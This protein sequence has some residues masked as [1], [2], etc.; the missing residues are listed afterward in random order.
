MLEF[1]IRSDSEL[2]EIYTV[3]Y[4]NI[5]ECIDSAIYVRRMTKNCTK[6]WM[7]WPF[8]VGCLNVDFLLHLFLIRFRVRISDVGPD[9]SE[10]PVN[11]REITRYRSALIFRFER[12]GSREGENRIELQYNRPSDEPM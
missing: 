3:V 5:C 7:L 2:S 11:I 4:V 10:I 8:R 1:T 6:V 9:F 12:K